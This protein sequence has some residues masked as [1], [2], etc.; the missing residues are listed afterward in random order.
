MKLKIF[1][2]IFVCLI[3]A[4]VVVGVLVAM[5]Y[6]NMFNKNKEVKDAMASITEKFE[7]TSQFTTADTITEAI[8]TTYKGYKVDR[9]NRNTCN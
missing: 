4:T 6:I 3:I 9:N 7:N 2:I 5:Q 1:K 8:D